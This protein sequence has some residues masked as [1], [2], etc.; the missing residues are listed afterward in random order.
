MGVVDSHVSGPKIVPSTVLTTSVPLL[1]YRRTIFYM[2]ATEESETYDCYWTSETFIRFLLSRHPGKESLIE[3]AGLLLF[4]TIIYYGSFPFR[5]KTQ[6]SAGCNDLYH[7]EKKLNTQSKWGYTREGMLAVARTL[8]SSSSQATEGS[9]RREEICALLNLL[10]A[11]KPT[12]ASAGTNSDPD[13]I[14]IWRY[15]CECVDGEWG[16]WIVDPGSNDVSH[17]SL[18]DLVHTLQHPEMQFEP[19]PWKSFSYLLQRTY[20]LSRRIRDYLRIAGARGTSSSSA[21]SGSNQ[22]IAVSAKS[23]QLAKR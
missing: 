13:S 7:G 5:P 17:H 8:P 3:T 16:S 19:V 10:Q 11:S 22:L 2:N 1:E 9:I 12:K 18:E 4:R 6:G 15:I 23:P 20:S 21:N 14:P